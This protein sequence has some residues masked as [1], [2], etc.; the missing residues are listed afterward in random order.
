MEVQDLHNIIAGK[1]ELVH[2]EVGVLLH[3]SGFMRYSKLTPE[4][5]NFWWCE[6][7]VS[8]EKINKKAFTYTYNWE[9]MELTRKFD[10]LSK[11]LKYHK[12]TESIYKIIN[13]VCNLIEA[14]KDGKNLNT[15]RRCYDEVFDIYYSWWKPEIKQLTLF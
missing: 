10:W 5:Y 7:D 9:D 12:P 2:K 13:N 8:S 14:D 4:N 15:G 6:V 1:F 3:D 11:F